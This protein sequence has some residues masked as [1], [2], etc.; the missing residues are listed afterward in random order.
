M[1]IRV[2]R[3]VA[4]V[5]LCASWACAK[6]DTAADSARVADSTAKAAASA[7]PP[8]AP[9][10]APLNDANIAALL[11]EANAGDSTMGHLASTKGKAA[12]VK[13]FGRDMMR[14]HHAL[15]KAGQDLVKKI[16]VTPAPPAGDTLPAAAQ[17]ASDKMNGMAAG[18]DWDKAY[19]DGEVAVHQSVLSLLQTA[20]GAA[21]D[22]SLKAL[23]TKAI[24][25]IESHLK[26]AQDIQSKLSSAPAAATDS[27]K[28]AAKKK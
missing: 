22:T 14:D 3:G 6:K 15:R 2:I 16:N 1:S 26:K 21:G 10:A 23:I 24:P 9:A 5:A 17:S 28:G 12:S 20:Q 19:I 8:P 18:A 4:V 25:T 7:A 27:G 13:E 11:D